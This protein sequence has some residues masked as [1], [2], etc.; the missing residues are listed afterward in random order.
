MSDVK[1]AEYWL[2]GCRRLFESSEDG[3][4]KYTVVV[5]QAIHSIIKSNDALTMKFLGKRAIRHENA[6]NLFLQLVK[7]NKI[8]S[9]FADLRKDVLIPAIQ[10]HSK[11]DYKGLHV[12]K[13]EAEKWIKRAEK[14]FRAAVESLE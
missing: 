14:F 13:T 12:S 4:E 5:A 6:V 7:E 11:A 9:K 3:H 2:I 8:P 10:T 1:E